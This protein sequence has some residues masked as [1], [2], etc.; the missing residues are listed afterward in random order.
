VNRTKL[1][2]LSLPNGIEHSRFTLADSSVEAVSCAEQFGYPVMV[3][4]IFSKLSFGNFMTY[5]IEKLQR[6]VKTRLTALRN[7]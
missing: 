4:P 2:A 5:N 1:K 3:R 6:G 7:R